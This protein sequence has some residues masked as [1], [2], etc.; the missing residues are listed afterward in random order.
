[1]LNGA[2]V[3]LYDSD[4]FVFGF[5]LQASEAWH[6]HLQEPK[7]GYLP[8]LT[9][10][11]A[12]AKPL[13]DRMGS[14]GRHFIM[15]D[16]SEK[17]ESRCTRQDVMNHSSMTATTIFT[18][19]KFRLCILEIEL[20]CNCRTI[21]TNHECAQQTPEW[22]LWSKYQFLLFS[23]LGTDLLRSSSLR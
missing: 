20:L 12:V 19:D 15:L 18:A 22:G 21:H 8:S 23:F 7:C 3:L 10:K 11:Y 6:V 14:E 17:Y 2:A 1:M 5:S 13:Y 16:Y 4:H 9:Q